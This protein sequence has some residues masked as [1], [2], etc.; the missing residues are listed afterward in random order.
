MTTQDPKA[1]LDDAEKRWAETGEIPSVPPPPVLQSE[2]HRLRYEALLRLERTLQSSS[3]PLT[4][5]AFS[6]SPAELERGFAHVMTRSAAEREDASGQRLQVVSVEDES[7]SF[8][9]ELDAPPSVAV[10]LGEP[11]DAMAP[12]EH[13]AQPA[14][15]WPTSLGWGMGAMIVLLAGLWLWTTDAPPTFW[16]KGG[17]GTQDGQHIRLAFGIG[18]AKGYEPRTRGKNG[19]NI[20]AGQWLYFLWTKDNTPGYLYLF[21]AKPGQTVRKLYPFSKKPFA[22]EKKERS[23]VMAHNKTA[24]RYNVPLKHRSLGFVG[25]LSPKPLRNSQLQSLLAWKP[26]Q[27]RRG[28]LL[29]EASRRLRLPLLWVDGFVI[30]VTKRSP[31]QRKEEESAP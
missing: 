8:I 10:A 12:H 14:W 23:W 5:R 27:L 13:S 19:M 20:A 11:E 28:P 25:V 31:P 16:Q 4:A 1:W 7:E 9:D 26:S 6:P 24:L 3:S 21:Q 30:R 29:E 17:S 15:S 22:V 18:D 2:E